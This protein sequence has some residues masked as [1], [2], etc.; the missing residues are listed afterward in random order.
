MPLAEDEHPF[1]L[2]FVYMKK[3]NYAETRKSD[4]IVNDVGARR[5][6]LG[7]DVNDASGDPVIGF[8]IYDAAAFKGIDWWSAGM[9]GGHQNRDWIALSSKD[10][11]PVDSVEPDPVPLRVWFPFPTGALDTWLEHPPGKLLMKRV[12]NGKRGSPIFEKSP[13]LSLE[14]KVRNNWENLE[15]A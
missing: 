12:K 5:V 6:K 2:W 13:F 3:R 8:N 1:L 10:I 14:L 4:I 9:I 15:T 7:V 11:R